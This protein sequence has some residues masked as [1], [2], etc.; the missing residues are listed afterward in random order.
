MGWSMGSTFSLKAG[1]HIKCSFPG[2]DG[3]LLDRL[4]EFHWYKII[5]SIKDAL[6]FTKAST[7][8]NNGHKNRGRQIKGKKI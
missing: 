7:E 5:D 6:V 8:A 1:V 3:N 4:T 2:S